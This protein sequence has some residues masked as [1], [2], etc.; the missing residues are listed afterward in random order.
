MKL[1]NIQLLTAD[2][3]CLTGLHIGSS[4]TE[5]HIGGVDNLVVKSPV[6]HLPYIPGSSLKGKMR[7]M[8]EWRSGAVKQGPLGWNDYNDETDQAKKAAVRNIIRLFGLGGNAKLTDK[9]A[10]SVGPTRA[11]FWDISLDEDWAA[12]LERRNL[13]PYEVKS[14]NSINRISGEAQNPRFT[15]RVPAGAKFKLQIS[16]KKL[17]GDNE[18]I[19][20]TLLEGL[21]LIELDGIGGSVSRG[22]GKVALE[23]VCIDGAPCELWAKT[24]AFAH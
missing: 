21:R 17:E 2:L 9:D 1:E 12:E 24:K 5:L 16:L 3:V 20:R 18:K 22:Y 4:D 11:S 10:E 13:T 19:L 23:N 7:S 8:L 15:E 6:T 14:E